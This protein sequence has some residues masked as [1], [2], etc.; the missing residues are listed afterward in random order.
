MAKKKQEEKLDE[1]TLHQEVERRKFT[2]KLPCTVDSAAIDKAAHDMAELHF[3][4]KSIESQ[5]KGAIADFKERLAE[6]AAQEATLARMIQDGT[7]LREVDC[8]EYLVVETCEVITR[9]LDTNERIAARAADP[10]DRQEALDL[11]AEGLSDDGD[12]FTDDPGDE[13]REARV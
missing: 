13:G 7:E 6:L 2:E 9:R 8:A 5:R 11:D 12:T 4:R 1:T 10:E 3:A